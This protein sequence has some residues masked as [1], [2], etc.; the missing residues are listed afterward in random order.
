V[1]IDEARAIVDLIVDHK[2]EVLLGRVLRDVGVGELL[3]GGHYVDMG[4]GFFSR[5]R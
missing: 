1:L 2:V 4:G 5:E 3:G